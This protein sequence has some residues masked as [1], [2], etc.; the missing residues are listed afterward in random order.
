MKCEDCFYSEDIDGTLFC[1]YLEEDVLG[2]GRCDNFINIFRLKE[3]FKSVEE[4][5]KLNNISDDYG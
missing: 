2:G 1:N 4:F 5:L 3:V